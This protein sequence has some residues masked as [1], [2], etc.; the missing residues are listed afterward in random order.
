M[1]YRLMVDS[2]LR[3]TDGSAGYSA[4]EYDRLDDAVATAKRIVDASLTGI[5][6]S[7]RTS[8]ELYEYYCLFGNHPYIVGGDEDVD[9]SSQGYAREKSREFDGD[10]WYLLVAVGRYAD[11]EPLMLAGTATAD[12]FGENTVAR[13]G[14]YENWGDLAGVTD[15][16]RSAYAEAERYLSQFAS[17]ATSGGEGTARM[18]DVQRVAKKLEALNA[19]R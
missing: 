6:A 11:A 12:D 18:A 10:P 19:D 7:G 4:G 13:A 14:F 1:R 8:D 16:A 3:S 9:F 17:W 5:A 2:N 15:E